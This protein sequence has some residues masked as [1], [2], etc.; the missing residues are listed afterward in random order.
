[1]FSTFGYVCVGRVLSLLDWALVEEPQVS[2]EVKDHVS[3]EDGLN[4]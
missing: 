4:V 2:N 3:F 1:M